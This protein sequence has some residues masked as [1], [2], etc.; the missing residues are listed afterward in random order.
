MAVIAALVLHIG[1]GGVE[2]LSGYAAFRSQGRATAAFG[3]N[4]CAGDGGDGRR[5]YGLSFISS[6]GGNIAGGFL[7][8]YL[9]ITGWMAAGRVASA[10]SRGRSLSY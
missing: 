2:I 8:F 4:V 1:G 10:C 9:A 6:S 7:A 5:R 3:T